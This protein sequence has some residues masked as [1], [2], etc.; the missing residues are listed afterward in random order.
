MRVLLL[1]PPPLLLL[2]GWLH[3]FKRRLSPLGRQER[4]RLC[5]QGPRLLTQRLS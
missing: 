5:W 3:I 4:L 1:L 2:Q